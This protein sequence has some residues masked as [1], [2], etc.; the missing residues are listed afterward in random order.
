MRRQNN[1]TLQQASLRKQRAH[2]LLQEHCPHSAVTAAAPAPL[3]CT[4]EFTAQEPTS[5]LAAISIHRL[6]YNIKISVFTCDFFSL[7]Y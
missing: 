7:F 3:P 2:T 4:M 1:H 5:V 6:A